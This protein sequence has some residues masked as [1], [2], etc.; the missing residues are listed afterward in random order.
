MALCIYPSPAKKHVSPRKSSHSSL[1][2]AAWEEELGND[3]DRDFILDGIKMV[4]T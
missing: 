4:L 2:L 1:C 3:I